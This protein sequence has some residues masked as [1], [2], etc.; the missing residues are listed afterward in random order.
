[1]PALLEAGRKD[2]A[3]LLERAIHAREAALEAREIQEHAPTLGQEVEILAYAA[4]LWEKF[5]HEGKAAQLAELS[6]A[7]WAERDRPRDQPD[8]PHA[9]RR[10]PKKESEREQDQKVS[11]RRRRNPDAEAV[12]HRLEQ[13]QE[14]LGELQH[15]LEITRNEL[16]Q[17]KER[18]R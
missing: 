5:G 7:M 3:E 1:M 9:D 8:Q 10:N 17:I 13:I 4:Q 14:R 15:A 6:R 18:R 11:D 12:M 2:T 16:R